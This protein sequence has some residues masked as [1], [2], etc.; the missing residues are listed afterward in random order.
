MKSGIVDSVSS[1]QKRYYLASS[2]KCRL[3]V[4]MT[5]PTRQD[6]LPGIDIDSALESLNC[7]LPT[8][9]RLLLQF[10]K[11][12]MNSSEEMTT[13]LTEG[14]IEQARELAHGIKGSSGYMCASKLCKEARAMEE[15][16]KTGDLEVA[17]E[18]MIPFCISLEEVLGGIAEIEKSEATN[19][20][21][22]P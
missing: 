21:E 6:S 13:F 11:Q 7:D 16:C 4:I 2:R 9:K 12:C 19:R 10:H 22:A 18:Q 15:A 1:P 3:L 17:M 8:F 20:P 5:H 14:D